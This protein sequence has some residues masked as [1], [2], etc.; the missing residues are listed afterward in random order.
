MYAR[1]NQALLKYLQNNLLLYVVIILFFIAGI[2][3]GAL[4]VRSLNV[5]QELE[6]ITYVDRFLFAIDPATLSNQLI[7]HHA[8]ANNLKL[9]LIIWF[10][11]LTVI[12]VPIIVALVFARGFVL[13]FT[14][15]FLVDQKLWS[16]IVLT[17][18][19]ILPPNL[20]NIPALIVAGATAVA[21]S[22]YLVR[23]R[24]R[25]IRNLFT[26][27]LNYSLIMLVL[28]VITSLAGVL[29]AY[30]SP[31]AIKLVTVYFSNS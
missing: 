4:G 24:S 7:A 25:G 1:V 6:L 30:V 10:L 16:G 3:F 31:L 15:G 11:G 27:F 17:L 28:C 9:M 14:V 22:S 18:T 12:G 23:G 20:L 5:K 29:E 2:S 8:V 19:A 21:F 13:G 26:Q